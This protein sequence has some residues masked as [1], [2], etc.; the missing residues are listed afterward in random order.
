MQRMSR[1]DSVVEFIVLKLQ[2]KYKQ[3]IQYR[4]ASGKEPEGISSNMKKVKIAKDI[5]LQMWNIF[6]I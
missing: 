6:D 2:E 3:M 5:Y 4:K 1:N